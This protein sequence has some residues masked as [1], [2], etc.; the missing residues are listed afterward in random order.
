[1]I[2]YAACLILTP[3]VYLWSHSMGSLLAAVTVF[4]FFT[5]GI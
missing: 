1:M 3:V 4:G 5:G 2:W